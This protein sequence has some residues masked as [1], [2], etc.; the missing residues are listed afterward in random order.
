[1]KQT[2]FFPFRS[3]SQQGDKTLRDPKSFCNRG[4]ILDEE[5]GSTLEHDQSA[6]KSCDVIHYCHSC[7]DFRDLSSANNQLLT[8]SLAQR[9]SNQ[10]THNTA[11]QCIS[12]S[13]PA[14][15]LPC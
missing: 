7:G 2:Y 4:S 3:C 8:L 15:P 9:I 6:D 11:V 1:M 13:W 14:T 12:L 5:V 10:L